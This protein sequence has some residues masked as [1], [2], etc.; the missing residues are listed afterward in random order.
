MTSFLNV[1]KFVAIVL[2]ALS[3]P[4]FGLVALTFIMFCDAGPVSACLFASGMT[5]GV[6]AAQIV[7]LVIGLLFLRNRSRVLL[8]G[9]LLTLS[10]MPIPV[11][12]FF[13]F[14]R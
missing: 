8:A 10:V 1:F 11:G 6:A 4:V 13:F 3:V 2:V 5:L 9:G 7:S 14:S 12:L